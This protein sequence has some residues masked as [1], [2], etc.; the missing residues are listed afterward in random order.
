MLQADSPLE[1]FTPAAPDGPSL[2]GAPGCPGDTHKKVKPIL[3]KI[4][5]VFQ[6]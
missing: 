3:E 2:P 4:S 6:I 5:A 1:P